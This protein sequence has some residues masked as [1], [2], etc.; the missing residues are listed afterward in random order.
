[1]PLCRTGSSRAARGEAGAWLDA[2]ATRLRA[3]DFRDRGERGRPVEPARSWV[4]SGTSIPADSC[5]T[6]RK[7]SWNVM[8]ER[9]SI[10]GPVESIDGQLT[11]RIPL[12]AGGDTLAPLAH[13]LGEAGGENLHLIIQPWLA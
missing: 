10:E 1:M 3:Q 11:L 13:G 7:A 12:A 2:V 6:S 9:I 4:R 8:H 5:T